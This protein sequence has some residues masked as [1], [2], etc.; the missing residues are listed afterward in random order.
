MASSARRKGEPRLKWT[1]TEHPDGSWTIRIIPATTE[2]AQ[3][4]AA[5]MGEVADPTQRTLVLDQEDL[6]KEK[7]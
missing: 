3:R 1:R 2:Q 5:I 6:V 4:I 7:P